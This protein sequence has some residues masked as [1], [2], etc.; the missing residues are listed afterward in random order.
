MQIKPDKVIRDGKVAVLYSPG[1][2]AGWSTWNSGD[3]VD[4][5]IFDRRLIGM[6]ECGASVEAVETLLENLFG[7]EEYIST[8]GWSDIKID[9]V[10]EG[11]VFQ[12]KE[13]D[14]HESIHCYDINDYYTA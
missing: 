9:W 7:T 11:T 4:F 13:Y 14:G 8:G 10:E 5:L 2:G 6:A 3:N 12:I 1:Y